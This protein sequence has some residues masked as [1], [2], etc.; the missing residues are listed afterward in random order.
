MFTGSGPN[1]A[2]RKWEMMRN[3]EYTPRKHDRT[4]SCEKSFIM[5]NRSKMEMRC[6]MKARER[7]GG[8]PQ[9]VTKMQIINSNMMHENFHNPG[10]AQAADI[11]KQT[12]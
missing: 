7:K 5:V 9:A 10:T 4:G 6:I 11:C 12:P 3:W 8:A 1:C 2:E